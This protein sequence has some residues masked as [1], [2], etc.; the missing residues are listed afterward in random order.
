MEKSLNWRILLCKIG[1]HHRWESHHRHHRICLRCDRYEILVE[2][3]DMGLDWASDKDKFYTLAGG[4]WLR[5]AIFFVFIGT[6][7][8]F[9]GFLGQYSWAETVG[10]VAASW[11]AYIF[12][13]LAWFGLCLGSCY[14]LNQGWR[15]FNGWLN[16]A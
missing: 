1:A 16:H 5:L 8:H 3:G 12:V 7:C 14:V 13:M 10:L 15:R 4:Y 2:R 9:S 6:I 11:F